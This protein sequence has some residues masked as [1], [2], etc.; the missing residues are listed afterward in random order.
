MANTGCKPGSML[1]IQLVSENPR[2]PL[3][4]PW[5]GTTCLDVTSSHCAAELVRLKGYQ[6]ES[7]YYLWKLFRLIDGDTCI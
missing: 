3:K 1:Q 7:L 4:R 5:G 2:C 6:S